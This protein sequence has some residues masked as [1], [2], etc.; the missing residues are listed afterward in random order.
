MDPSQHLT[1]TDGQALDNPAEGR[2][3]AN[4]LLPADAGTIR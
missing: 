3:K 1:D 4:R 2:S